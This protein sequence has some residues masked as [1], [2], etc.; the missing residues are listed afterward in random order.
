MEGALR[1]GSSLFAAP[2][3][4]NPMTMNVGTDTGSGFTPKALESRGSPFSK[5]KG[6]LT[7]ALENG[8]SLFGAGK[9]GMF[10]GG[11]P[12]GEGQFLKTGGF[13]QRE[14]VF[15]EAKGPPEKKDKWMMRRI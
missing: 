5:P 2:S 8:S 14:L 13:G 10:G 4:L 7:S 11:P 15:E 12:K 3:V 1:S 6:F 9:G